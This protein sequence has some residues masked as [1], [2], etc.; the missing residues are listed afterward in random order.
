MIKKTTF[1]KK[2]ILKMANLSKLELKGDEAVYFSEQFNK[3]IETISDLKKLNTANTKEAYNITGLR[4][5]FREDVVDP[6]R[7]LSHQEAISGAKKT[8][9]G[10]FVVKGI[11]R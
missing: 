8:H 5:V 11:F 4:N 3:T 1:D 2:F 10:Y 6:T 9:K 7:I